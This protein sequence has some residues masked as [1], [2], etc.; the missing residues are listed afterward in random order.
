MPVSAKNMNLLK[1][2]F[3]ISK[4]L[5][6]RILIRRGGSMI[7]HPYRMFMVG[8]KALNKFKEYDGVG[9]MSSSLASSGI[10][11]TKMIRASA[12]GSYTGLERTKIA[13]MIGAVI[14]FISPL[15]IIPDFLPFFGYLD[16]ASLLAWLFST[17]SEELAQFETWLKLQSNNLEGATY[18]E[19][20]K[21]AQARN[22]EG[23][24]KLTK[25]ELIQALNK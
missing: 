10:L 21:L 8:T 19:L 9:H 1:R 3:I 18:Q 24:S 15:D 23:R 14:Y 17:L 7:S 16:D 11:L 6:F 5:I 22:I 4:T 25:A 20:Y 12:I 2:G 13:M